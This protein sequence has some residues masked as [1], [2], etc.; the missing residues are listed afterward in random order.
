MEE[1]PRELQLRIIKKLDIDTRI[2]LKIPPCRLKIPESLTVTLE[3]LS[4]PHEYNGNTIVRLTGVMISKNDRESC[5]LFSTPE[6]LD[7]WYSR[8]ECCW[9]NLVIYHL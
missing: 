5:V 1:L 2:R 9:M 4:K 6:Y 8:G 7:Y 3:N